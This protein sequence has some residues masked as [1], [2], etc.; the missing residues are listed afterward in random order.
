MWGIF[1]VFTDT[2]VLCTLTALVILCNYDTAKLHGGNFIMMTISSY[3][4]TLS[5]F[6]AYFMTIAVLFFGFATVI[7]WAHYGC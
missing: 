6:A 4:A 5:D 3:S 1:E 7:C 2:I